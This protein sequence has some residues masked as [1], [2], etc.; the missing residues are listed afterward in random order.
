M[1]TPFSNNPYFAT[2]AGG[3]LQAVLFGLG[4][5]VITERGVEQQQ[6]CL[7]SGWRSLTVRRLGRVILHVGNE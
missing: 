7:P 6:P 4:G 3:M 5:L 2:A 1:E